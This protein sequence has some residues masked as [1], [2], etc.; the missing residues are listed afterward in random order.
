LAGSVATGA[1]KISLYFDRSRSRN[2]KK[3]TVLVV[4]GVLKPLQRC[5]IPMRKISGS[6]LSF[7]HFRSNDI[8]AL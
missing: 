1:T 8:Q 7:S 6:S 4:S 5:N 3:T 2:F